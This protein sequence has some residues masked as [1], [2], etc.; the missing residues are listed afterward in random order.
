MGDWL[1][2]GRVDFYLENRDLAKAMWRIPQSSFPYVEQAASDIRD[3]SGL[4]LDIS[5][6]EHIPDWV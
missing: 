5:G 4:K 3:I 2:T 1:H 6:I